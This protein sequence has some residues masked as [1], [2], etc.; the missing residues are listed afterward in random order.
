MSVALHFLLLIQ[1]LLLLLDLESANLSSVTS[2][3]APGIPCACILNAGI[4]GRLSHLHSFLCGRWRSE[5]RPSCSQ[6]STELS[7]FVYF[8]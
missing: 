5:L 4:P 8:S 7:V 2:Q 1:G 3:P 6:A